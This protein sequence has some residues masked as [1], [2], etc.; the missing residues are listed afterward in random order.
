MNHNNTSTRVA[1]DILTTPDDCRHI[2][3]NALK[4][5]LQENRIR[6]LKTQMMQERHAHPVSIPNE[7]SLSD[8]RP[9]SNPYPTTVYPQHFA[10][11][12]Y[13]QPGPAHMAGPFFTYHPLPTRLPYQTATP[14][15]M[16][17]NFPRYPVAP[18]TVTSSQHLG[19][20][21]NPY[22]LNAF[23][24]GPPNQ[25]QTSADTAWHSRAQHQPHTHLQPTRLTNLH[26]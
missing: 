17:L 12:Q 1:T 21:Q 6:L 11:H 5:K 2:C 19:N 20:M 14:A 7:E 13:H 16:R 9:S 22:G 8:L 26:T 4:E 3:Y 15:H 23:P 25:T 24:V 18:P 10:P